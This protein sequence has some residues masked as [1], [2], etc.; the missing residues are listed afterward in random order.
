MEILNYQILILKM[1]IIL[2]IHWR[3]SQPQTTRNWK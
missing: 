3:I 2:F 1:S